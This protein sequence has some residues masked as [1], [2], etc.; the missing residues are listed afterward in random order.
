[1]EYLRFRYIFS[2]LAELVK[3][4]KNDFTNYILRKA[5]VNQRFICSMANWDWIGLFMVSENV[6]GTVCWHLRKWMKFFPKSVKHLANVVCMSCELLLRPVWKLTLTCLIKWTPPLQTLPLMIYLNLIV[7]STIVAVQPQ[8]RQLYTFHCD[9]VTKVS[10]IILVT[11]N[12]TVTKTKTFREHFQWA[13]IDSWWGDMT[14]KR[15]KHR[16]QCLHFSQLRTWINFNHIFPDKYWMTLY[17]IHDYC[18]VFL[19]CWRWH[20]WASQLPTPLFCKHF[21][22]STALSRV[23]TELYSSS[24]FWCVDDSCLHS[25]AFLGSGFLQQGMYLSLSQMPRPRM[26]DSHPSCRQSA[27]M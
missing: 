1:M 11:Y 10:H 8:L 5:L 21:P 24:Y 6:T 22:H 3:W 25:K 14:W 4:Q 23:T 12:N 13:I 20:V 19:Q 9:W 2:K 16:W 26:P 17:S 18:N 7:V 15:Q 27:A